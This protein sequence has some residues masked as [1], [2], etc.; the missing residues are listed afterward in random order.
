[1]GSNIHDLVLPSLPDHLRA[2]ADGPSC[3]DDEKGTNRMRCASTTPRSMRG[4]DP[5]TIELWE[6]PQWIPAKR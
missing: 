2:D 6:L 1:M 5:D 3:S 4:T